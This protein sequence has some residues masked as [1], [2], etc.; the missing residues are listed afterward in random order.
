MRF[1]HALFN[2]HAEQL[3]EAGDGVHRFLFGRDGQ[4]DRDAC[5]GLWAIGPLE[6]QTA[7]TLCVH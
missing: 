1:R 2:R 5:L 3:Q 6:R 4:S 7:P